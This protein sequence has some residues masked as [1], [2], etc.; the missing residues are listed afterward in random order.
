M[1][2]TENAP[3]IWIIRYQDG[4]IESSLSKEG[5]EFKAKEYEK[6]TGKKA[7]IC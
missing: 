2:R 7:V 6:L 4:R 1:E 5:V 3:K